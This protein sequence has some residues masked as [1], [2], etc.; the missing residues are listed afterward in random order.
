MK[1]K[2]PVPWLLLPRQRAA[3]RDQSFACWG[4]VAQ[5]QLSYCGHSRS[6]LLLIPQVRHGLIL[7]MA[8]ILTRVL[9]KQKI[10]KKGHRAR[11]SMW[12][13]ATLTPDGKVSNEVCS[14]S[15]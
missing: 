9:S 12:L 8:L 6:R 2:T 14:R 5:Y 3:K 10:T 11:T 13:K 7:P 4:F 1:A 15:V